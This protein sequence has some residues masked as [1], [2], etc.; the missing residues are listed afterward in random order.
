MPS[1]NRLVRAGQRRLERL[2]L[3]LAGDHQTR[4]PYPD[5]VA[6]GFDVQRRQ[7]L[8]AGVIERVRATRPLRKPAPEPS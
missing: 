1:P 3:R 7:R 8:K 4:R 5:I 6:A 2:S